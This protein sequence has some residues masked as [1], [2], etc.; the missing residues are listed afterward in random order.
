MRT[1]I[2]ILENLKIIKNMVKVLFNGKIMKS[3]L[4]IG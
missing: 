3:I 4:E 1:A 2:G